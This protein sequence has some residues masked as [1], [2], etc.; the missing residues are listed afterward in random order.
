[1]WIQMSSNKGADSFWGHL[2]G[3]LTTIL[4]NLQKYSHEPLAGMH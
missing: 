1:M 3:K 4:I 2:R